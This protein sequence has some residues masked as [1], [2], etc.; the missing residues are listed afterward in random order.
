MATRLEI[1]EDN[2]FATILDLIVMYGKDFPDAEWAKDVFLMAEW[3]GA[4]KIQ[5][6]RLRAQLQIPSV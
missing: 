5:V 3:S 6:L 2:D 1:A 4:E